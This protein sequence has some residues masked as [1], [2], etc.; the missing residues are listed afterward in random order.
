MSAL[1]YTIP[2]ASMIEDTVSVTFDIAP[3]KFQLECAC[4]QLDQK[5]VITI[6]PTGAGKMLT[7]W[8]IQWTRREDSRFQPHV[9]EVRQTVFNFCAT[10]SFASRSWGVVLQNFGYSS[11]DFSPRVA[12]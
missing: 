1:Q 2:D 7:F 11:E 6:A 3:C 12:G 4:A 10:T 5:D 9:A 8:G